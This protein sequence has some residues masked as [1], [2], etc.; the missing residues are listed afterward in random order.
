[1]R[2]I[3]LGAPGAGKGTQA[4]ILA[5]QFSI[6]QISTGEMLREAV[7]S[8]S[9]LGN[10]VKS[11]M[12][13]GALV[14][15][16]LIFELVQQRIQAADCQSGF[17]FDGFPRTIAQAKA[18]QQAGISIDYVIEIAIADEDLV[19]RLGG[20]RIHPASGR[21][22]HVLYH[23]PKQR[24]LD[25]ITGEPLVQRDDDKD[26]TVRKRLQVYHNQTKPLIEFFQNWQRNT[27]EKAPRYIKIDGTMAVETVTK[28]IMNVIEKKD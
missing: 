6:P 9:P 19:K 8:N 5:N 23:P 3:F 2:I 12:Q 18:L 10:Q 13:S 7:K 4:Q 14:S 26:E 20:R 25:D 1:M 24:G 21:T 16:E 15:D 17:I 28:T 27:T 11:V 22:Y